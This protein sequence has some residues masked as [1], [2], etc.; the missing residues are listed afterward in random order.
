MLFDSA[1]GLF[2]AFT[3]GGTGGFITMIRKAEDELQQLSDLT[4]AGDY[5]VPRLDTSPPGR[6]TN[7]IIGGMNFR[8]KLRIVPKFLNA[9]SMVT[10]CGEMMKDKI[11]PQRTEAD[12]TV[13]DEIKRVAR[14]LGAVEVGFTE[15][16]QHDIFQ[17]FSI[18]YKNAIVFTIDMDKEA[19]NTAPSYDALAEVLG[20]YGQLGRVSLKLTEYLRS[21]GFGAYPGFPV[22]GLVD[23]VRVAGNAGIGAIGYHGLLISPTEGARQRINVV[24]TNMEIPEPEENPHSWVLDF[25]DDCRKC[26]RSCPAKAIFMNGKIHPETGRKQTVDYDSCLEYFG[27][28]QGCAV[29]VKVCPFS[30]AGYDK[31]KSGYLKKEKVPVMA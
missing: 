3:G 7:N 4:P 28:N 26:V 21:I 14:S 20:T 31:I 8:Q 1:L 5:S 24:F 10:L 11:T 17:G 25:C 12:E 2:K 23:D 27:A 6:G 9:A 22:G 30:Q 19:I 18:P 29:C 16:D 15:V 13:W